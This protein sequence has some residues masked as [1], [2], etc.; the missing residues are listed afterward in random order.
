MSSPDKE[1]INTT[2]LLHPQHITGPKAVWELMVREKTDK[3]TLV[4]G[5]A[6]TDKK[7]DDHF[8]S[9]P[10]PARKLL[11][12]A[13]P[14]G[15]EKRD[16]DI[17]AG[18]RNG[19]GRMDFASLEK[20]ALLHFWHDCFI[21][22]KPYLHLWK[23][24]HK[25]WID[26]RSATVAPC[27]FSTWRP[28]LHFTLSKEKQQLQFSCQVDL[29]GTLY[30]INEFQRFGF[31]LL[32]RN[33]YFILGWKEFQTLERLQEDPPENYFNDLSKLNEHILSRLE[34]DY[35]V[36][37]EGDFNE[38]KIEVLPVNRV[39]LQEISDSFLMLT[40][41][42]LYEGFVVESQFP[43]PYEVTDRGER[44]VIHRN[45]EAENEFRHF[46]ESLHPRFPKQMNGT[47]NLSFADAQKKQWFLKTWYLLLEKQIEIAGMDLLKH[48]RYSPHSPETE[49]TILEEDQTLLVLNF[50]LRFGK[51]T[52]DLLAL[53]KMLLAGQ[54]A[55]VLKD[56]S[57]GVLSEECQQQYGY[58]VKHGKVSQGKL[59]V[60]RWIALT[61]NTGSANTGS[62]S[63]VFKEEW[64]RK[65]KQWQD[66]NEAI[67][68]LPE[69]LQATL[70]PY[71]HKGFEWM[72]LLAEAGA[73]ACLA[74]DMGL[75]KT[76]QTIAVIAY[77][78]TLYPERKHLVVCPSGLMY[79]WLQEFQR[80]TPALSV[81]VHHGAQRNGEE[82]IN[83]KHQ[84]IL[85]SYGTLRSDLDQLAPFPFHT[86]VIDES[87]NIKNPVAQITK[88][89]SLIRADF[90]MALSGTPVL[91]NT[92]DL[93]AQLNFLLPG[94]FGGREFFKKEY[95]DPIDRDQDP[96]KTEALR[97]LT[98]P[99]IL[100][101]TKEQVAKDLPDK[102]ES[103]LW[104][105]MADAQRT[106]YEETKEQI[107]QNIFTEIRENG[108]GQN[109]L[110][111]LNGLLKLRQICNS[112]ELLKDEESNITASVKTDILLQE[113][114]QTVPQHKALVFSQ[115]TSMLD[116]L[117][118]RLQE[119]GLT[120]YRI[121]GSVTGAKRQEIVNQ[122]QEADNTVPV[123]LISLKAGNAG[124][125]LTAAD[126]VFLFDPWWNTA[127]EQQAIDRTHRIGQTK[128]VF[129][130][131][132]ICKDSIEERIIQ[133]QERKKKLSDELIGEENGF[134][135][136]L[137]EDDIRFLFS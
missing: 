120:Y 22:L 95:A 16:S 60:A 71:Q 72:L 31:L 20:K 25:V 113:L 55:I 32:S 82:I 66:N 56:G 68:T 96:E 73:G 19:H 136:S 91:N 24:Y 52:V 93:Y 49:I 39:M 122:F 76:L 83:G 13:S 26:N 4:T 7:V 17:K 117:E 12:S 129:A 70:R 133:L 58:L 131:K 2:L 134:V 40:P 99:F 86:V 1:A 28:Q 37:R 45:K 48:F 79:N 44:L 88:A 135:K 47:Y 126:Y 116:L 35:T 94:L 33:E 8:Y 3:G 114:L 42:W 92:F 51:E 6:L 46:L 121:D 98:L 5:T 34:E 128:K 67:Y 23:W 111:V 100:R 97:R 109:K 50:S 77:H 75:G 89:V 59:S 10:E 106:I 41:Q 137:T 38:Q 74:D 29:N 43:D 18:F 108:L 62:L 124:L 123:L 27:H 14:R 132:M 9:L 65:W 53:Q 80:F 119:A 105:E 57:L 61:E 112:P 69:T 85:T 115:F 102:T 54:K 125:N 15:L 90:R 101:R 103:I 36:K 87:H 81:L 64:W 21:R 130:Y 11:K 107:Q 63:P 110:S 104:C 118:K 30:P 127:V 78:A 84:V